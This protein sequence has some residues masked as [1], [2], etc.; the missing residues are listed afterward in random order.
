MRRGPILP[1][2]TAPGSLFPRRESQIGAEVMG[3]LERIFV[4]VGDRVEA[5]QPL[6]QIDR[7]TYDAALSQ[8]EAGLRLARAQRLQ[9]QA[10]LAR[11]KLLLERDYA[12]K[13]QVDKL[14]T[15]LEVA[16]AMERQ[17][18]EAVELARLQCARTLVRAP[19]AGSVSQRLA[20]E[21][22][23]ALAQPQTVVLVLQETATLEARVAIPEAQLSLVHPGDKATLRVQG[24]EAPV[25]TEVFAVADSIDPTTRTY[26]V[27]MLVPNEDRTLKAG[28]FARV[29][30]VARSLSDALLVPREA[31][32]TED[33]ESRV[34]SIENGVAVA[35]PVRLGVVTEETVQVL[36]GLEAGDEIIVGDS[37]RSVAPG[38]RVRAREVAGGGPAA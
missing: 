23:T 12:P 7:A 19:F 8:A 33:G 32:R 9:N 1:Q 15:S 3:R 36:S 22:T 4:S 38:M 21:G 37:A 34:Y 25:E 30:I 16:R 10:D 28:V 11:M 29:D 24:L 13:Q 6:F 26:L 35:V 20:D 27:R 17:A 18:S 5:G 14:A 2:V 31:V